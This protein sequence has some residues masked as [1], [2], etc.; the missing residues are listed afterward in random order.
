M[1]DGQPECEEPILAETTVVSGDIEFEMSSFWVSREHYEQIK[2]E[3]RELTV[4]LHQLN[5]AM[6]DLLLRTEK[7]ENEDRSKRAL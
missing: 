6:A 1:R 5:L 4:K 7:E 2:N 3:N